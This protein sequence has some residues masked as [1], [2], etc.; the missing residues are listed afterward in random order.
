MSKTKTFGPETTATELIL[1]AITHIKTTGEPYVFV[2]GNK[3]VTLT[4]AVDVIAVSE[5]GEKCGNPDCPVH[6][7]K[8]LDL[9]FGRVDPKDLN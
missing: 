8:Q 7:S 4:L 3:A 2:T 6:G 5:T 9:K 1:R